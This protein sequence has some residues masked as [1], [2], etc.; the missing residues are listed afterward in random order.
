M[1]NPQVVA[2]LIEIRDLL[3]QMANQGVGGKVKAP[4]AAKKK[5]A[6]IEYWQEMIAHIDTAWQRK[7]GFKYPFAPQEMVK[8]KTYARLYMPWGVMALWDN[9]L[10]SDDPFYRQTGYKI[11]AFASSLPVLLDTGWK[12]KAEQY[13]LK[14]QPPAADIAGLVAGLA[15]DKA[16]R[17]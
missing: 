7:K 10:A 14:L 1:N 6:P 15:N 3:N 4:R 2:L 9:F 16:L 8:L 17:I 12:Q 11:G 13:R 5:E